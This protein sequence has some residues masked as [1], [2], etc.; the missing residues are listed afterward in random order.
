MHSSTSNFE[1]VI[2]KLPW[3]GIA[4]TVVVAVLIAT[5]VWEL[6]VRSLGYEP[7][8]N[9][10]SDLWAEARRRVQAESIVLVGDSRIWFDSDL[11]E[12][13]RGLGKRPVQLGLAGGCAYPVLA[14]LANDEH[15][16]GTVICSVV[17]GLFFA[18][19]GSPPVQR[20]E[21][22]VQ[23]FHGQTL[24][25]RI[26][27]E[28][29]MPLE[30]SFAFLKQDDLT[31]EMLLKEL[32]IPDRANAQVPPRLP[33][34]FCSI[35]GE[36]R[37]R[38]VEQCARPGRLQ[39]RVKNGWLALFTPPPPPSFVP[40]DAFG[41]SVKAAIEGRFRDT[42]GAVEKLRGRGAKIVFVRFPMSGVL[43]E[44]EDKFTPRAR[45]WDPL[46]QATNTPGIYFEDYP[47]LTGF[48]CPEWS[49]LSAG[50]SVEF[51]K[52]LVPHLRTALKL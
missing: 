23:R 42:V 29:S 35:D 31:L 49:H 17:P 4:V 38:M 13:E 6:Y 40:P 14:D 24:A 7:T 28:V 27:H 52:R 20:G 9:D 51:T 3:R 30:R 34:Y 16:H 1:R 43:K 50:D 19:P 12:L 8:L 5:T 10:T 41:A 33:P 11:D 46:L 21:K 26:S 39:D 36:R 2:P 32:P 48:E 37:A 15:F 44:H 47:E 25:Q 18:P 45:T 22:A